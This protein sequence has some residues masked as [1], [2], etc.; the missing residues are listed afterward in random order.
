MTPRSRLYRCLVLL[1]ALL[2]LLAPGCAEELATERPATARIQGVVRVG[3]RPVGGGWI[4]F[5]PV[6][7]TVG[8]LRSAPLGPDGRFQVSG[9]A[10]GRN[11]VRLV[12]SPIELP[13]PS[14]DPRLGFGQFTSPLRVEVREGASIDLDVRAEAQRLRRE[15]PG[16]R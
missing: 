1:T 16:R 5:L 2:G 10:V 11:L 12:R 8:N 14:P 9:V 6:E 4:E 15:P 3:D 13:T 7:G